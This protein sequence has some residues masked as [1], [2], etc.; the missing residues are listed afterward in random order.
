M[1]YNH[2]SEIVKD[3]TFGE[4]ARTKILSGVD[5][6]YKAVK[7]TLGASGK[8]VI[9]EDALGQP[10]ITK[11]GVTVAQSVVLL[12]PVENMG[13]TLIKQ[14][15]QNTVREA[16]DGTTTSTVLAHALLSEVYKYS[17]DS[18]IRS[19]KRGIDTAY[20][21]I[22][23]YLDKVKIDVN[24]KLLEHVAKIS[25]NNDK[26][27]GSIIGEA[28]NK[29]GKQGVV[30]LEDSGTNETYIDVIDGAQIECG[31]KSQ[32]LITDKESGK[33]VLETPYILIMGSP[34][35]NIRKI[36]S[37]LEYVIKQGRSLLIVGTVEQQPMSA[38]L[39]NKIKGNIKVNIIDAPG[40]GN[41]RPDTLED[42]AIMT[43]ARVINEELGDDI[44]LISPEDLGE[45]QKVITDDRKTIIT[46]NPMTDKLTERIE[47]VQN[48]IDNEKDNPFIKKRLEERMA[49]LTGNV[50]VVYV[51]AD[52]QVELKEKR[53]RVEDAIYATKAALQEGIV[54]GGGIAL[55]NAAHRI[56]YKTDGEKLL[57][58]AICKPWE[59]I[60]DNAGFE[61]KDIDARAGYGLDVSNGKKVNMLKAGIIDPV[62]VTKT[63][64][65]NAISVTKTI[66]SSDCVISNIRVENAGN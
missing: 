24:E 41:T 62:L 12:D 29:V 49:L 1:N 31:L 37:V 59:V 11:D 46:L 57:L 23:K 33:A 5:K 22:V 15:A 4:D 27:L 2:P 42:L 21:N 43:G 13:A 45:A 48:L 18:D 54:P 16:G 50:A 64:L 10:I 40:F 9:Y 63:A 58:N 35:P 19:L 55:L 61:P 30:L 3:L 25:T 32:H 14:A 17:G 6:L 34:V 7:S 44:D 28:F 47:H 51:G 66:I 52:S 60:L 26:E 20:H 65:K 36:Q 38:L 8:A 56:K 53:D 39:S